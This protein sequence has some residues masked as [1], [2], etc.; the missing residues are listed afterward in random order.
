MKSIAPFASATTFPAASVSLVTD[1]SAAAGTGR[2][3]GPPGF[4]P[5]TS[6]LICRAVSFVATQLKILMAVDGSEY[7]RRM[8]SFVTTHEALFPPGSDFT[9]HTVLA[10]LPERAA[11]FM[12][13]QS[14][15]T[16]YE[17]EAAE[18]FQTVRDFVSQK[19]STARFHHSVGHPA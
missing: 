19:G 13:R 17:N 12:S 8:I 2:S 6:T 7:T 15:S 10:P 16:F 5:P 18:V 9:V 11:A 14:L 4:E 3:V 1:P